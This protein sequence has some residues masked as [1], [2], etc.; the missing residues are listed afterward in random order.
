MDRAN[1]SEVSESPRKRAVVYLKLGARQTKNKHIT[2]TGNYTYHGLK[3]FVRH[4]Q[5][6]DFWEQQTEV[7]VGGGGAGVQGLWASLGP[8]GP[9]PCGLG[10]YGP[11]WALMG[12]ALMG[13]SLMGPPGPLWAGP[14]RALC[15][16]SPNSKMNFF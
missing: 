7:L 14:I 16:K 2:Q 15:L 1:A 12:R 5:N 10:P 9:G 3:L 6:Y 11:P 4:T 13:R 8:Y